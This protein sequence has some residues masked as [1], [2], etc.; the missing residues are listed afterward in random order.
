MTV[1][2]TDAIRD[3]PV[4]LTMFAAG[5]AL[6]AAGPVLAAVAVWRSAVLPRW[7]AVPLAVAFVLFLPQFYGPPWV[8]I[9]H[10]VLVGVACVLLAVQLRRSATMA[11]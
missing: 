5:L 7:A 10:G 3:G 2:L 1:G 9:A 4:Q 11:L 6:L 8:R